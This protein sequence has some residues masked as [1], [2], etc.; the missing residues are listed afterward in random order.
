[1]SQPTDKLDDLLFAVR[2]SVRYHDI[3]K[4]HFER[5]NNLVMFVALLLGTGTL[6]TFI[7][8]LDA[9]LWV[10][11]SLPLAATIL[12]GIS[13]VCRVSSKASIH[14]DLK[15]RFITL[16]QSIA[17]KPNN[18]DDTDIAAWIKER[19]TIESDELPIKRILDVICHNDVMR[20]MGYEETHPDWWKVGI[21]QRLFAQYF[22]LRRAALRRNKDVVTLWSRLRHWHGGKGLAAS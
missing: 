21:F 7:E 10:Q 11:L 4:Q 8:G 20:S 13:L 18:W 1:M 14:N 6:A 9:T 16:E 19:L 2:R 22:D 17:E 3:R 15:R 12:L 5:I